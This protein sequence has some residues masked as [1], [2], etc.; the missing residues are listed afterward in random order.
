MNEEKIQLAYKGHRGRIHVQI[1]W[2]PKSLLFILFYTLTVSD[3][4]L[5]FQITIV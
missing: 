2:K 1:H 3:S 4:S 5:S